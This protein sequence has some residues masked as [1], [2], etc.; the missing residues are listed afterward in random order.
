MNKR[1]LI[2][3]PEVRDR[4]EI[5]GVLEQYFKKNFRHYLPRVDFQKY[6][7]LSEPIKDNQIGHWETGE[8]FVVFDRRLCSQKNHIKSLISSQYY[9]ALK[10]SC[11]MSRELC[12][13]KGIPYIIYEGEITKKEEKAFIGKRENFKNKIKERL[14][15]KVQ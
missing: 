10:I 2:F 9:R 13:K 1:V 12:D 11:E 14:E 7:M 5:E 3:S 4:E 15:A 8:T 6:S